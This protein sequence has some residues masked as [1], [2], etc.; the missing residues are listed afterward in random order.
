MK[1]E[2][3]GILLFLCCLNIFS[4]ESI[5]EYTGNKF[6][7]LV[8][9]QMEKE[10]HFGYTATPIPLEFAIITTYPKW[11]EKRYKEDQMLKA[12]EELKSEYQNYFPVNFWIYYTG[13]WNSKGKTEVKI[14]DDF[15]EYLFLENAEGDYV[16]T[17]EAKIPFIGKKINYMNDSSTILILFENADEILAD[18]DKVVIVIGG[19]DL[20]KTKFTY[21]FPFSQYYQD[22]PQSRNRDFLIH[23]CL[24]WRILSRL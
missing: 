3:I 4:D 5:Q 15:E 11:I 6:S 1:R 23:G 8:S 7:E 22:A 14:P 2:W 19:V 10:K 18:S 12:I 16:R 21:S 24:Y 17:S 9:M 13:D 20:R